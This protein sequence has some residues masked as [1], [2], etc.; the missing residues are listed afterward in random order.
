[1][2]FRSWLYKVARILGD[3]S[4]LSSGSPKKIARRAKNKI[5]PFPPPK[6]QGGDASQ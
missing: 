2:S 6:R 1:M 4:A 5:I 3:I